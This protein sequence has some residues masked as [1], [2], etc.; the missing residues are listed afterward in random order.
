MTADLADFLG[1]LLVRAQLL[2]DVGEAL[3]LL[4][5]ELLDGLLDLRRVGHDQLD[6]LLDDEAQLV[7]AAR[8]ERLH[9]GDLQRGIH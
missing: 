1:D 6:V 9:Q 3:A 4:G 7:D 5:V 8:I 2:E